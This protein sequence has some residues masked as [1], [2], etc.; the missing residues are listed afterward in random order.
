MQ[1]T[2]S[3]LTSRD[4]F[5]ALINYRMVA[6]DEDFFGIF[7]LMCP[8]FGRILATKSFLVCLGALAVVVAE[9]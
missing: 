6:R 3:S 4:T 7:D 5:K 9:V 8:T 2:P 1:E